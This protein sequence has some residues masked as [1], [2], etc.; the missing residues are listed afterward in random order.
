MTNRYVKPRTYYLIAL[1]LVAV[2]LELGRR[3]VP[4]G[5]DEHP[6]LTA[7]SL[8]A[9]EPE[10]TV[11]EKAKPVEPAGNVKVYDARPAASRASSGGKPAQ[12]KAPKTPK[13][14]APDAPSD[15]PQAGAPTA[16]EAAVKGATDLDDLT[17]IKGIGPTYA[18]RLKDAGLVTYSDI[19]SSSEDQ[20]RQVTKAATMTDVN[21]WIAQA[22]TFRQN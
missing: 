9:V 5:S 16:T 22:R 3:F 12:P 17:Q 13:P 7:E 14:S 2:A 10:A 1:G 4:F 11:I 21:E 18:K 15:A 8:T 6:A 20:L 19:A